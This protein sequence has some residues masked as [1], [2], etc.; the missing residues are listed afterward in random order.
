MLIFFVTTFSFDVHHKYILNCC[1]TYT[2]IDHCTYILRTIYYSKCQMLPQ[3]CEDLN[4]IFSFIS[5]YINICYNENK[6]MSVYRNHAGLDTISEKKAIFE[7]G[8]IIQNDDDFEDNVLDFA[9]LLEL[10]SCTLP[11]L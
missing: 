3:I 8:G 9:F 2:K 1:R 5:C 4:S 6:L 11:N 10:W 7:A